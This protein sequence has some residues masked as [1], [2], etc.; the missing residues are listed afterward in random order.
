MTDAALVNSA[1]TWPLRHG[2]VHEKPSFTL[3]RKR[4]LHPRLPSRPSCNG[5]K[6]SLGTV[7]DC[8]DNAMMES[9]GGRMQTELLNRIT[10][11][12]VVELSMGMADHIDSFHN[13]RRSHS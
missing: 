9:Y 1:L 8:Y 2:R 5:L 3:I 7:G 13:T 11:T 4:N 10:W 6:F 12:T